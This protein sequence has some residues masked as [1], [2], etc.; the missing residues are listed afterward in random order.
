MTDQT[1]PTAEEAAALHE[2]QAKAVAQAVFNLWPTFQPQGFSGEAILEGVINGTA[3]AL[4]AGTGMSRFDFADV[5]SG[6]ADVFRAPG[7]PKRGNL[8]VVE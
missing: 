7:E 5:L 6:M 2:R 1:T 4:M 3:A 8:H